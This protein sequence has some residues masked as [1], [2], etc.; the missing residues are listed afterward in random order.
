MFIFYICYWC[1]VLALINWTCIGYDVVVV[2]LTN[3]WSE[4]FLLG[5]RFS[6]A[7]TNFHML[8]SPRVFLLSF[9]CFL[10]AK[11]AWFVT[12]AF[13]C[14]RLQHKSKQTLSQDVADVRCKCTLPRPLH[15]KRPTKQL[16]YRIY[17]WIER[18]NSSE[19]IFAWVT[20]SK[21]GLFPQRHYNIDT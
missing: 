14:C 16:L 7:L 10:N 6:S 13:N 11:D 4:L 5:D 21:Q 17:D 12:S 8:C 19:E 18:L 20:N 3:C 2:F 15:T 1:F 9:C